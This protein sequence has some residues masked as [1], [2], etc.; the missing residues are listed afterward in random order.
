MAGVGLSKCYAAKYA[1]SG[2]V[3]SYSDGALI[4]KAVEFSTSIDTPDDNNLYAD[5]AIAE[6]DTSFA[7][8]TL[9]I[10]T[11]DMEQTAAAL[12]L[13]ITPT[14]VSVGDSSVSELIYD[15]DAASPDLGYGTIVKKKVNGVY[16]YRAVVLTKI[17]FNVPEDSATT[18]GDTIEWQTPSLTAKI[19]RDDSTKHAWKR[20]ATLS[21][22]GEAEAY[23]K[24]VL[25]IV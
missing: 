6:S 19:M 12:I 24:Q 16:K 25:N 14:T 15:D 8:G 17:K 13:G 3:V 7:G 4:G 18:Q 10:S 22:E 2:G 23:I 1:A 20:E 21:T 5:N 9:T 11:D